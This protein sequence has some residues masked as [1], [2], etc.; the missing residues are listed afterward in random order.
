[1]KSL[2]AQKQ[3]KQKGLI[4]HLNSMNINIG[5]RKKTDDNLHRINFSRSKCQ[6]CILDKIRNCIKKHMMKPKA[7]ANKIEII[8]LKNHFS[9]KDNV[10]TYKQ[11]SNSIQTSKT[12]VCIRLSHCWKIIV[13]LSVKEHSKECFVILDMSRPHKILIVY[14]GISAL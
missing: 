8:L 10:P 13:N 9:Q 6:N 7:K 11:F 1:M 5:K 2:S 3:Q 12:L 14:L 4:C